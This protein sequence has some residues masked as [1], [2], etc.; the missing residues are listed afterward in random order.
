M[1]ASAHG[2]AVSLRDEVL[3]AARQ[4]YAAASESYKEG[5]L[6]YLDVLDAQRTLMDA[7]QSHVDA[8]ITYHKAVAVVESLIGT[9]LTDIPTSED[10][11]D[12]K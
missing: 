5:K 2:A 3:P 9:G 7:R 8:L 10:Q 1:L 12:G 4:A 6:G 11:N